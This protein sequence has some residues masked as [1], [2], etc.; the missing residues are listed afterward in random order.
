MMIRLYVSRPF[1]FADPASKGIVDG[2]E[3][4]IAKHF[5]GFTI[6]PH[7][8]GCWID[9]DG[10]RH[11]DVVDVY[12]IMVNGV[13]TLVMNDFARRFAVVYGQESIPYA[14]MHSENRLISP[15]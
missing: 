7:A 8:R 14:I 4:D 12:D 13:S 1:V 15:D 10:V 3:A 9:P 5:G 6:I 2:I 11:D